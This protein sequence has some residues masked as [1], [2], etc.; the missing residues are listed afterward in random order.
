MA[1]GQGYNSAAGI[2]VQSTLGTKVT[3][4]KFIDFISEGVKLQ[5]QR[6]IW[7]TA[8]ET[9]DRINTEMGRHSEGPI[10]VY[11]A[12]E[13]LESW[14]KVAFGLNSCT[15]ANVA[16]SAY[17]HTYALKDAPK[18]P[19]LTLEINRDVTAFSYEG[20]QIEEVTFTQDA[21]EY[22]KI[23]FI[24][25]GRDETTGAA[26]SPSFASILKIH[27]AQLVC[28]V[29]TVV[30]PLN[31]FKI[32]LKNNLTGFRPQLGTVVTR[33]IIRDKKRAVTG[34]ISLTFEDTTRYAEFL[35]LTNVALEFKYVGA[36]IPSGGGEFF[37]FKL[38]LPQ[39]NWNGETPVVPGAGPINFSMPFTAFM[40]S[41]AANDELALYIENSINAVT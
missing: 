1:Q 6:K 10:E 27:H 8:S 23:G 24:M 35:A 33:E 14:L 38:N 15:D 30:T 22:L 19:G 40:T 3:P 36:A 18:S 13:G 11:G 20:V 31:S 12:F 37:T 41:R 17:S 7:T 16:A 9:G 39:V 32:N 4:T 29:A 5:T 34:E 21:G 2:G 28:K 25:R 26:T